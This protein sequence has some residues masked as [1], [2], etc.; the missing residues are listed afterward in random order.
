MHSKNAPPEGEALL[1]LFHSRGK[2]FG[3][4]FTQDFYD[5][6]LQC[7]A[8]FGEK[9]PLFGPYLKIDFGI[10]QVITGFIPLQFVMPITE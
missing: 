2:L 7:L 8:L 4:D 5:S 10:K 3:G 1:L 9:N 6:I